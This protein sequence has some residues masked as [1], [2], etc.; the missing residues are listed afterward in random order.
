MTLAAGVLDRPP[1]H[2]PVLQLAARLKTVR[3]I[4]VFTGAGMSVE[5]GVPTF[6]HSS[7]A[8]WGAFK[9]EDLAT[10]GAFERNPDRVWRWYA[11]RRRLVSEIEPHAGHRVLAGLA[12][13]IPSTVVTQNVDGLHQ[14]AGSEDVVELHGSLFHGVCSITGRTVPP[15]YWND[16]DTAAPCSP[17]HPEG[18]VRPGVVWFGETLPREPY[19]TAMSAAR[20]CDLVLSIGTSGT[21]HPAADLPQTAK[22]HG[23]FFVEINPQPTKLSRWADLVIQGPAA[24]VLPRLMAAW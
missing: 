14:R 24:E 18:R 6:R 4:V 11:E 8:L 23:A 1:W 2:A 7:S 10:L 20:A 16:Q 3:R 15:E 12:R 22:L 19:E 17:Y 5:A 9:P 13:R 21:V